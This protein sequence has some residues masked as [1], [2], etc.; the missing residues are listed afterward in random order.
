MAD[1]LTFTRPSRSGGAAA[2][3]GRRRGGRHRRRGCRQPRCRPA[4]R[5]LRLLGGRRGRP[6]QPAEGCMSA[7]PVRILHLTPDGRRTECWVPGHPGHLAAAGRRPGGVRRPGRLPERRRAGRHCRRVGPVLPAAVTLGL[8]ARRRGRGG[9][10]DPRPAR[11]RPLAPRG[12]RRRPRREP[13]R[14]RP[15]DRQ[16]TVPAGARVTT[17]YCPV[18]NRWLVDRPLPACWCRRRASR[19][20]SK[21]I[22]M[23]T[24]VGHPR[25]AGAIWS[26]ITSAPW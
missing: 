16:G 6:R 19:P 24:E 23:P 22:C 17:C 3:G 21:D 4:G 25:S 12:H 1:A 15:G 11:G 7:T 13:D 18:C 26:S 14:R 5:Q 8:A 2:A 9:D 10:A 20:K